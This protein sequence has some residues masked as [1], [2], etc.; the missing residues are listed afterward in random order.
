M[1]DVYYFNPD[2][3]NSRHIEDSMFKATYE[4]IEYSYMLANR[5]ET[6]SVELPILYSVLF[7]EIIRH[8]S[9]AMKK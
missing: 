4:S 1:G 8:K 7:S 3:F 9:G 6:Y 2:S 5:E